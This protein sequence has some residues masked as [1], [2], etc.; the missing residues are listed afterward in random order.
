[1]DNHPQIFRSSCSWRISF[2][3]GG[4]RGTTEIADREEKLKDLLVELI[5]L[6]NSNPFQAIETWSER[7]SL[8]DMLVWFEPR[9]TET[10]CDAFM[11]YADAHLPFHLENPCTSISF[12]IIW[13]L[14]G[15]FQIRVCLRRFPSFSS[16]FYEA[17]NSMVLTKKGGQLCT[18]L[19]S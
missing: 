8:A 5:Y 18:Y 19:P 1:L 15:K 12:P 7:G 17:V 9:W 11:L 3:K 6:V 2:R 16:L 4:S 14:I 13:Y 10:F